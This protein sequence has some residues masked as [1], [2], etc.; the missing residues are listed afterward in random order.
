M[1]VILLNT[2]S[3]TSRRL[4]EWLERAEW[5]VAVLLEVSRRVGERLAGDGVRWQASSSA[6]RARAKPGYPVA[7]LARGV[8][9]LRDIPVP[10][11][12][13]TRDRR[14]N[15][16]IHA[17]GFDWNG[18]ACTVVGLHAPNAVKNG[19]GDKDAVYKQF[20]DWVRP[21]ATAGPVIAALDTNNGHWRHSP[22]HPERADMVHQSLF[23]SRPE[24]AGL[25]EAYCDVHDG[26]D[27]KPATWGSH[28]YDRVFLSSHLRATR[29][30]VDGETFRREDNDGNLRLPDHAAVTLDLE[31]PPTT[32]RPAVAR[33]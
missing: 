27:P 2:N 4:D 17:V 18:T 28:F 7:I 13:G 26:A 11:T 32:T 8:G 33:R 30:S 24:T 10:A 14:Y 20:A 15:E 3:T 6:S 1:R 31:F 5:D 22:D 19:Q 16:R 23:L 9:A 21:L 25:R 12:L 29:F